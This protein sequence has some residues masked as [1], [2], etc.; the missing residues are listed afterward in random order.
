MVE[1][2]VAGGDVG[3]GHGESVRGLEGAAVAPALGD[4]FE[5]GGAGHCGGWVG[6]G[7][8]VVCFLGW[9][10]GVFLVVSL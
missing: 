4:D 10:G 1:D 8:F 3:G 2:A 5:A 9:D 7:L 6:G